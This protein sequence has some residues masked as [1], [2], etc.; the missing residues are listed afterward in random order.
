M[1]PPFNIDGTTAT[2]SALLKMSW[3]MPESGADWI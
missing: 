3:G 1:N 2:H